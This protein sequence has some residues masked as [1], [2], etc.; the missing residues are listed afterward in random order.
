MP[1]GDTLA[2]TAAG[3]GPH[4]VG[5]TIEAARS[6][7]PA[8]SL[9]PL[10]G[11]RVTA[12]HSRGK[13]LLIDCSG[14]VL[15]TH[16]GMHGAWHR[17]RPGERWRR[18]PLRARVVLEVHGA[19]VVAFDCSSVELFPAAELAQHPILASLG[20]DLLA[21]DFPASGLAEALRRFRSSGVV[22]RPVAEALVDQ[23]L[24]AGI[25]NV[26][27]SELLWLEGIDPFAPVGQLDDGTI[28]NLLRTAHRLLVANADRR[29]FR[30]TTTDGASWADGPLWVYR[31]RGR[32][33]RRCGQSIAA[34]RWGTPPRVTYWCPTCQ[35]PGRPPA[36]AAGEG[37]GDE[38]DDRAG[39]PPGGAEEAPGPPSPG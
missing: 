16:L 2:R 30:R 22:H 3:L 34:A 25:G 14:L 23:T 36:G 28:A 6:Q 7:P 32:P 35:G 20:P 8:P 27:K 4:L 21:P 33:C 17:Y 18:N 19:V 1:E 39:R 11:R 15:R 26:F 31:R 24:V 5:R 29:R 9:H 10:V 12:V 38:L 13:H 37:D